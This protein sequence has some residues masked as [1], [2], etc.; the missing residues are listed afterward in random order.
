MP[1]GVEIAITAEQLSALIIDTELVDIEC[2]ADTKCPLNKLEKDLPLMVDTV[3]S[4]GKILYITLVKKN[5]K[6]SNWWCLWCAFG[7]TGKFTIIESG[8][9]K[10]ILRF[11]GKKIL[12]AGRTA[13]GIKLVP[14]T[15]FYTPANNFIIPKGLNGQ[16]EFNIYFDSVR[17]FSKIELLKNPTELGEK[18][19]NLKYS[20]LHDRDLTF[21]KFYNILKSYYRKNIS[22]LLLDAHIFSGIGNYILAESLYKARIIPYRKI[23][24]LSDLEIKRLYK[25]IKYIFKWSYLTQGGINKDIMPNIK[26]PKKP[27]KFAVYRQEKD[28]KGNKVIHKKIPGGRTGHFV[29]N[30]QN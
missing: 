8:H 22:A 4:R 27:F 23:S 24:T 6:L 1:E 12:K 5:N 28:P 18:L 25:S 13:T 19:N 7:M 14:E 2:G 10:Y 17:G 16:R 15:T 9:T 21:N 29:E 30:I 26:V 11:K 20:F 3:G